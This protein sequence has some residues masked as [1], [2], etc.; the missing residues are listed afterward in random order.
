MPHG[1]SARVGGPTTARSAT[2]PPPAQA[3]H[4]RCSI[5][6]PVNGGVRRLTRFSASLTKPLR[7]TAH[8]RLKMCGAGSLETGSVRRVAV[9]IAGR[10]LGSLDLLSLQSVGRPPSARHVAVRTQ[11]GHRGV[12]VRG[13]RRSGWWPGRGRAHPHAFVVRVDGRGKNVWLIYGQPEFLP[14]PPHQK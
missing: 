10:R 8:E 9:R 14:L 6:C 11:L 5:A 1:V 4:S 13:V 12:R 2:A 7:A 3:V